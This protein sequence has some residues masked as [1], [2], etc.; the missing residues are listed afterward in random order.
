[1][2]C[3]GPALQESDLEGDQALQDL[4]QGDVCDWLLQALTPAGADTLIIPP[5]PLARD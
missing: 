4:Q 5:R 2:V 1:M 3:G